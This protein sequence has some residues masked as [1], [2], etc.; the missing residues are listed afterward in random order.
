MGLSVEDKKQYLEDSQSREAIY[1]RQIETL[2]SKARDEVTNDALSFFNSRRYLNAKDD[3][4]RARAAKSDKGIKGI[5][6]K[7]AKLG[8]DTITIINTAQVKHYNSEG[9][10]LTSLWNDNTPDFVT[11]TFSNAGPAKIKEILTE[12]YMGFQ[13]PEWQKSSTDT[14]MASWTRSSRG[15]MSSNVR[16]PGAVLPSMQLTQD[17]RKTITTMESR[18]KSLMDG[19]LSETVRVL[20]KDTQETVL[21]AE[22]SLAKQLQR[23][24]LTWL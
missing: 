11:I 16:R 5:S 8:K 6:A 22:L 4:A 19:A 17:L 13:Y 9:R 3:N 18:A 2:Y 12:F 1:I 20:I 23:R 7:I 21:K 24:A 10:I 14:A 15:I